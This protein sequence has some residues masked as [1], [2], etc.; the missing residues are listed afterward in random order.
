MQLPKS[1]ELGS[2]QRASKAAASVSPQTVRHRLPTV[3]SGHISPSTIEPLQRASACEIA[4]DRDEATARSQCRPVA[5]GVFTARSGE[6]GRDRARW[7]L[8][9]CHVALLGAAVVA[10]RAR[11]RHE[12]GGLDARAGAEALH[13]GEQRA[14]AAQ[15]RARG[16]GE[17]EQLVEV[18]GAGGA[19]RGGERVLAR[20]RAAPIRRVEELLE[21]AR[22]RLQQADQVAAARRHHVAHL[23]HRV[24]R[25]GQGRHMHVFVFVAGVVR[26]VVRSP[27]CNRVRGLRR[28]ALALFAFDAVSAVRPVFKVRG[29]L[30][31]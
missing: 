23:H 12:R 27:V 14:E 17:A 10:Q 15:Q 13:G 5:S 18:V 6:I 28:V 9:P 20:E 31:I 30:S 1:H 19:L 8:P 2:G 26:G 11:G 7:R 16:G 24:E 3:P 22:R 29:V 21:A 25:L 4:G